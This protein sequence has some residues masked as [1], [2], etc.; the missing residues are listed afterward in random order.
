MKYSV[1]FRILQGI[2]HDAAWSQNWHYG[3][4][5]GVSVLRQYRVWFGVFVAGMI[6]SIAG[7]EQCENTSERYSWSL[8]CLD[9]TLAWCRKHSCGLC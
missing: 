4:T 2:I 5:P 3:M 9:T 6:N 7:D 8:T 1:E